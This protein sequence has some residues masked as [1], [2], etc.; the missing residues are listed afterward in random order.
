[1]KTTKN[2]TQTAQTPLSEDQKTMS[3]P[4]GRIIPSRSLRPQKSMVRVQSLK[5]KRLNIAMKVTSKKLNS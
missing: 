3:I 5:P 1:M 4:Q 2:E